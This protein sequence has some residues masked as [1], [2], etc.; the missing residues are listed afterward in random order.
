MFQFPTHSPSSHIY[1]L[2]LVLLAFAMLEV[3]LQSRHA[4][5]FQVGV[6]I[7][8][9]QSIFDLSYV[10]LTM[11]MMVFLVLCVVLLHDPSK[12]L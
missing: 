12:Q 10:L 5:C 3:I 9:N 7:L 8:L 1:S 6:I 2:I 11:V 4:I